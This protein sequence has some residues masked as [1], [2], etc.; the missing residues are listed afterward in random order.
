MCKQQL[1]AKAVGFKN[2]ASV[3]LKP[4][5]NILHV[6]VHFTTISAP[7][8]ENS[9]SQTLNLPCHTTQAW[10]RT[11][12]HIYLQQ[13]LNL[14]CVWNKVSHSA[15][16]APLQ[17]RWQE[18]AASLLLLIWTSPMWIIPT[19]S[20]QLFF[21][22]NV[23]TVKQLSWSASKVGAFLLKRA[24]RVWGNHDWAAVQIH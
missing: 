14:L 23:T 9:K 1:T 2:L 21:T 22:G 18:A 13:L 6:I 19:S 10:F 24:T 20:F 3:R 12:C 4:A 5:T 11:D 7:N 8:K 17:H 15:A 16:R